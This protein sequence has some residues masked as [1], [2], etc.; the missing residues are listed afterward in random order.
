VARVK[1]PRCLARVRN[2][3]E[4]VTLDV[5]IFSIRAEQSDLENLALRGTTSLATVNELNMRES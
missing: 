3:N 5:L 4:V 1:M 2:L